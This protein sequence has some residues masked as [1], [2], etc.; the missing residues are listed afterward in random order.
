MLV[1]QIYIKNTLKNLKK[2]KNWG[3]VSS[4]NW[5]GVQISLLAPQ[6]PLRSTWAEFGR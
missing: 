3:G 5:G 4:P 6:P 1:V 2:L